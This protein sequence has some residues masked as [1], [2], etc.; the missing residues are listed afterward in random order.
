MSLRANRVNGGAQGSCHFGQKLL[1]AQRGV[2]RHIV[3]E[4]PVVCSPQLLTL[5]L[6][7]VMQLS[8][9]FHIKTMVDLLTQR[10]KF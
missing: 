5:L 8:Q 9:D 4:E 3:M 1:N 7:I 2:G 6:Q 10:N